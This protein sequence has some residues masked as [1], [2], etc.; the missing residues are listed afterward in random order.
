MILAPEQRQRQLD[1]GLTNGVVIK[2]KSRPL[3]HEQKRVL[4]YL[5]KIRHNHHQTALR[6][7]VTKRFDAASLKS[8]HVIDNNDS[9]ARDR[10]IALGRFRITLDSV[11]GKT[12]YKKEN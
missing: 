10:R 7:C 5:V 3:R 8:V 4:T 6:Q 11:N 2:K 9:P 1:H 12:L